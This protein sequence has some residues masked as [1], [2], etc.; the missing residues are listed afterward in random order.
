LVD[1]VSKHFTF[2]PCGHY[3]ARQIHVYKNIPVLFLFPV[4]I[5][6]L[7]SCCCT[8]PYTCPCT[9][10]VS[11][12]VYGS[13]T[14][15][16][17]VPVRSCTRRWTRPMYT[18]RHARPMYTGRTRPTTQWCTW[19][20]HDRIHGGV[21]VHVYKARTHRIC[22]VDDDAHSPYTAVCTRPCTRLCTR[23]MQALFMAVYGPWTRRVDG[24]VH[25][26]TAR[27]QP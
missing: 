7:F 15:S 1:R 16:C 11:I 5:D 18:G 8:R 25:V 17:S 26:Y 19:P 12:T 9:R 21:R 20:V 10:A 6:L 24:R 2:Q 22:R 23:C 13:C 3:R 14:W 27:T 4:T